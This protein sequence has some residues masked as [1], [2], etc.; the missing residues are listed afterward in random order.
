[1]Y[2]A[3]PCGGLDFRLGFTHT[4]GEY[5]T[6]QRSIKRLTLQLQRALKWNKCCA[7]RAFQV[8]LC[9]GN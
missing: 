8:Y 7:T 9:S 1:M 4:V 2:S 6:V 3:P 5:T